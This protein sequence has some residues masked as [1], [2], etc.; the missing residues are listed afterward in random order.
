MV[1]ENEEDVAELHTSYNLAR[2]NYIKRVCPKCIGTKQQK[3][4]RCGKLHGFKSLSCMHQDRAINAN[5]KNR[6][7]CK[8]ILKDMI[9]GLL[10]WKRDDYG[11]SI[12]K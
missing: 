11:T 3:D 8:K 6:A 4:R 1:F 2:A 7:L 9:N 12:R 5:P 10:N